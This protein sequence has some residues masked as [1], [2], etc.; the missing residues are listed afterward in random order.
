[1]RKRQSDRTSSFS[2]SKTSAQIMFGLFKQTQPQNTNFKLDS[3]QSSAISAI[4]FLGNQTI[5]INMTKEKW[6]PIPRFWSVVYS[7]SR[8]PGKKL[9]SS[10]A[11]GLVE[12]YI[13]MAKLKSST[14]PCTWKWATLRM[15][16]GNSCIEQ[17]TAFRFNGFRGGIWDFAVC[18]EINQV[19]ISPI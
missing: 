19:R 14:G 11:L 10:P 17:V 16:W 15:L 13:L 7:I 18:E 3:S 9:I 5:T 1:M 6:R 12:K 4:H 2:F 8:Q